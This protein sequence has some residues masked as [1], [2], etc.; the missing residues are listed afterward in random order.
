MKQENLTLRKQLDDKD[1][2]IDDLCDIVENYKNKLFQR[3][4]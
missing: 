1:K 3:D 2:E 4:D